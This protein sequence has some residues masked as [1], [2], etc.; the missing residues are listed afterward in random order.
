MIALTIQ[1]EVVHGW[2]STL[3][4]EATGQIVS[5]LADAPS[6]SMQTTSADKE[7]TT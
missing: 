2:H 6:S 3:W 4:L 1:V 5:L 7:T